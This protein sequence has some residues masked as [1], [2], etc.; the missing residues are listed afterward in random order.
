LLFVLPA[1]CP[2]GRAFVFLIFAADFRV[3]L[4]N[5]CGKGR[6]PPEESGFGQEFGRKLEFQIKIPGALAE[7]AIGA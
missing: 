6:Q 7:A 5:A 1:A 2:A 4:V 3:Y